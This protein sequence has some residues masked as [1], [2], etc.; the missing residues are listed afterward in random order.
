M[1]LVQSR[2]DGPMAI[3]TDP[4]LLRQM[5]A[6]IRHAYE[7]SITH[8]EAEIKGVIP[9]LMETLT[10]EGPYGY[11]ILPEVHA[12]GGVR[13]PIITTRE[14]IRGA[15]ELVRGMS[16]LLAVNPLTEIR[17]TW[18]TFQ[19]N[20]SYGQLKGT[21]QR[22]AHETLALFPSSA[23]TGITGELV[24][25]RVPRSALGGGAPEVAEGVVSE[26][27][28]HLREQVFQLHERHLNALQIGDLDGVLEG[29]HDRVA[30][31]VRDYVND[32]G[33]LTTLEGKDAHRD[34]YRAFFDKYEVASVEP[35]YRAAEDW[36]VFAE[37]RITVRSRAGGSGQQ[38]TIA[39][40][41]AEFHMPANDGRFI[42]RI[43]HGT[44]PA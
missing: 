13:L 24:W 4:E 25:V 16:D 43:G 1:V 10:P 40:H 2:K 28:M 19:D 31:A 23:G 5:A 30:S 34:Y 6:T 41:T 44:D 26:D 27:E 36:Y 15:Y 42:A 37:V 9:E 7:Q 11:T 33:T 22:G 3:D 32:T 14:G 18:Y 12:D 17:G 35:L 8:V 20:I 38:E 39:F 21:D 29:L